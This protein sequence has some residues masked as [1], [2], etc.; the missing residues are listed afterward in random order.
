M[1]G[2]TMGLFESLNVAINY[3]WYNGVY[4][5]G[6]PNVNETNVRVCIALCED[7]VTVYKNT[8]IGLSKIFDLPYKKLHSADSG[9]QATLDIVVIGHDKNNNSVRIPIVLRI[10]DRKNINAP[11]AEKRD[12]IKAILGHN[13]EI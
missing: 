11:N 8:G 10:C 7:S 12:Q 4:F 1:N 6:H 2:V 5:S 9:P 3:P 13:L